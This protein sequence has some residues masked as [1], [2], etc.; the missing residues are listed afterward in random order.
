M[1]AMLLSKIK[2]AAVV[3]VL[4][5]G[6]L[7]G[8]G[9]GAWA[10]R[11]PA[12][13]ERIAPGQESHSFTPVSK[14]WIKR[15]NWYRPVWDPPESYEGVKEEDRKPDDK[16]LIR[17]DRYFAH[18]G[19]AQPCKILRYYA[20]GAVW[21]EIDDLNVGDRTLEQFDRWY[22]PDGSPRS[23]MHWKDGKWVDGGSVSP[24]GRVTHRFKDGAG[25]LVEYG[26]K[27]GNR[28]HSWYLEGYPFLEKR[29]RDGACIRIR[30]NDGSDSFIASPGEKQLFLTGCH[31]AWSRRS[32]EEAHYQR[33]DR[34][35]VIDHGEQAEEEAKMRVQYPQRRADFMKG[36]GKRLEK[37]GKTWDEL[38]IEFIRVGDPWPE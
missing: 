24:D 1:K 9:I 19:D 31:E 22:Y 21:Q 26:S 30:L 16:D 5:A 20:S 29:Y 3:L 8:T 12:P 34:L 14:D 25:E 36:Y 11:A 6:C 38:K 18:D 37:A 15:T 17:E 2:T 7:L 13:T 27:E 28:T 4:S 10:R 23:F 33:T 32:G 35:P